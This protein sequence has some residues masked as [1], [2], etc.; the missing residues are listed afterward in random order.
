MIYVDSSFLTAFYQ[1]DV[2]SPEVFKRM[3]KHPEVWLSSLNRAEL[4]NALYR[5]VFAGKI[6]RTDARIAWSNFESDA[7]ANVWEL[8]DIPTAAWS[9]CIE[10]ARRYAPTHGIRTLDSLHVACALEL[11]ARQFWTFDERQ[12]RLAKAAGLKTKS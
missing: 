3:A 4:A 11:G 10:L 5:Q 7:K 6:N 1:P 8:H 9:T 12:A 2:H